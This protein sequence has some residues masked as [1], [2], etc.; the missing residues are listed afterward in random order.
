MQNFSQKKSKAVDRKDSVILVTDYGYE[1]LILTPPS[2]YVAPISLIN[3]T[4]S[5]E[6]FTS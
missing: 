3:N 1:Q 6:Y 5:Y 4:V 2:K